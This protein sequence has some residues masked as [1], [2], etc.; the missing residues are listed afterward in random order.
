MQ[1]ERI[2]GRRLAPAI[3]SAHYVRSCRPEPWQT[4]PDR[5]ASTYRRAPWA[6]RSASFARINPAPSR[7]AYGVQPDPIGGAAK[8]DRV[9]Q[10]RVM[11]RDNVEWIMAQVACIP[12]VACFDPWATLRLLQPASTHNQQLSIIF[13]TLRA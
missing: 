1:H 13:A 11:G 5:I 3:H 10:A 2:Q 4:R 9:L 12:K 6:G 8:Q 7:S